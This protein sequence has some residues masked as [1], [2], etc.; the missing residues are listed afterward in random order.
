M[1]K[2]LALL[3]VVTL[4]LSLAAP[5]D[6]ARAKRYSISLGPSPSGTAS[7][8]NDTSLDLSSS[9]APKNTR[10]TI[11]G[12]LKGG[13]VKGKRVAVYATNLST[14]SRTRV[15]LGSAKVDGK[16][17]FTKAFVPTSGRAGVYRIDLVKA[18]GAGRTATTKS[19]TIRVFEFVSLA[20][21]FDAAASTGTIETVNRETAGGTK[22][23]ETYALTGDATA[24]YAIA[25]YR[26]FFFN[27]KI[28][29]SDVNLKDTTGTYRVYQPSQTIFG[30]TTSQGSY[31]E[32]T[33][34]QGKSVRGNESFMISVSGTDARGAGTR[35]VLGNPKISCTYPTAVAAAPG[36]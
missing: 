1:R 6:A 31:D 23:G 14:Q 5:A 16:G 3:A 21:F 13:K 33:K 12:K 19:F 9:T 7:T 22:W 20:R 4:A 24:V 28:G 2:P 15:S 18:A 26:C 25:G 35:F 29:V 32:P 27:L 30:T 36:A 17:Y 8:Y 11:R 10:T 34:A